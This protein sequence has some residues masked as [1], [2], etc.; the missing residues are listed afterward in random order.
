MCYN[1]HNRQQEQIHNDAILHSR[2]GK[3]PPDIIFKDSIQ[4]IEVYSAK[5]KAGLINL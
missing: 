3:L 2:W 1:K 5:R 4:D